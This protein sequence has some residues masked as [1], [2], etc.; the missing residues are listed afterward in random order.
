MNGVASAAMR[1]TDDY[2]VNFGVELPRLQDIAHEFIGNHD[3]AQSLWKENVRECR[4]L[5]AIIQPVDSFFPEIADIWVDSIR[6]AEIAQT[7]S[8][9]LFQRL[10]YASQ[11][12]F[13]WMA[14]EREVT[15]LCGFSTIYH[16]MRNHRLQPR[17]VDELR[18]QIEAI[19]ADASL[20]LRRLAAN[21]SAM[22]DEENGE[23]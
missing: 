11:K 7:T 13:E 5:A 4:I 17:S 9:M 8:L 2:R 20:P 1:Q 15:Q 6:T 3:L 10:P 12:A 19:P 14:S 16:L 21:I 23:E 18:D 22:I